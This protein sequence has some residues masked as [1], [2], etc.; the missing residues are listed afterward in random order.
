MVLLG[1]IALRL[2]KTIEW[3]SKHLRATNAPEA[4]QYIRTHYRHGWKV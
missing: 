2:N 3:D 1:N 4:A